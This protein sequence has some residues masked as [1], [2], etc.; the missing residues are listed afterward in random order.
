MDYGLML[1]DVDWEPRWIGLSR[2][3]D[4]GEHELDAKNVS[5]INRII[6][7]ILC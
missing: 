2:L 4:L 1:D 6:V 3:H 7:P 5:I